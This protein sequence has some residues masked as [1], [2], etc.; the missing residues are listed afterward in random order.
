M[1]VKIFSFLN[2]QSDFNSVGVTFESLSF[3]EILSSCSFCLVHYCLYG[4]MR[5]GGATCYTFS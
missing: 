2:R 3:L 1:K 4:L 5:S